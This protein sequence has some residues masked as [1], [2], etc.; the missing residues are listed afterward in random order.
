MQPVK[1]GCLGLNPSSMTHR[2]RDFDKLLAPTVPWLSHFL[3][4]NKVVY[5][6]GLF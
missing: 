6:I 4:G 1:S 5:L 2:L 3:N